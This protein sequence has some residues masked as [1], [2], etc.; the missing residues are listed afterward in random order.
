MYVSGKKLYVCIVCAVCLLGIQL[1]LINV[2]ET[3]TFTWN[4]MDERTA[5]MKI[6]D[7]EKY[8]Y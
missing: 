7:L 5:A 2:T 8:F 6:K 1:A 3:G 4:L